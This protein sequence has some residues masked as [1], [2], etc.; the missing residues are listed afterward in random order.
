[1]KKFRRMIRPYK[2]YIFFGCLLIASIIIGIFLLVPGVRKVL[3][4]RKQIETTAAEIEI[5]RTKATLLGSLTEETL[6]QQLRDLTTALPGEV[7]TVSLFSTVDGV[8]TGSGVTIGAYTVESEAKGTNQGAAQT[9]GKSDKSG[10]SS[11]PISLSAKGTMGQVQ[12]F[13]TLLPTVRRLFRVHNVAISIRDD[14][15]SASVD[16]D[17]PYKKLPTAIGGPASPLTP[18]SKKDE[19]LLVQIE[20]FP[21][22]ASDLTKEFTPQLGSVPRDPFAK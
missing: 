18:I 11:I 8:M 3:T 19:A 7:S 2:E 4:L 20:Q 13:L 21:N 17:V 10:S 5:L 12:Q 1:M 9:K 15:V 22:Y 6:V 16:V 14:T